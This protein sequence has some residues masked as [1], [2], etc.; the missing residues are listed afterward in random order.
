M[1]SGIEKIFKADGLHRRILK[2]NDNLDTLCDLIAGVN[3]SGSTFISDGINTFT[4][5]TANLPT[6]NVTGLSVD[7]ITVSGESSFQS[8]S[9]VTFY[10]GSTDLSLLIGSG[11]GGSSGSSR[12]T[13]TLVTNNSAYTTI[14]IFT[15]IATDTS[16]FVES[17]LTAHKDVGDGGFWKRTLAL[18]N[19]AGTLTIEFESADIDVQSSGLTTTDVTYTASGSTVVVQVSGENAKTYNW[20]SNWEI[21]S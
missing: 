17:H 19:I 3:T 14:S 20:T 4:G 18:K 2:H 13:D 6:V 1:S 9:A 16:R 21:I 7:N 11:G 10:S 5:G 8:I 12:N 15:G